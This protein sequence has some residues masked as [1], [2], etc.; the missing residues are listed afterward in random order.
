MSILNFLGRES[1]NQNRTKVYHVAIAVD[2]SAA[3]YAYNW[4]LIDRRGSSRITQ[5]EVQQ[6]DL[7]IAA[8]VRFMVGQTNDTGPLQLQQWF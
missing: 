5:S 8:Y 4:R 1:S 3:R 2:R 6:L 7:Q